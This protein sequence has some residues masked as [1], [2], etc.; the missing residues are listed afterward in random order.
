MKQYSMEFE[1]DQ[2]NHMSNV[3][4]NN[5]FW[6]YASTIKTA[7]QDISKCRKAEAARH[8]RNFRIYDHWAEVDPITNYVPVV[9][10][11]D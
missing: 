9:Y 1:S 4:K 5:H 2:I 7:K 11:E 8:P 3:G 10:H 6:G